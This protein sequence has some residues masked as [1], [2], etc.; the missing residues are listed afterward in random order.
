MYSRLFC[1]LGTS[2]VLATLKHPSSPGLPHPRRLVRVDLSLKVHFH[3]S[4]AGVV[5]PTRGTASRAC[6]DTLKIPVDNDSA[7]CGPGSR[8]RAGVVDTGR[9]STSCHALFHAAFAFVHCMST[10]AL[11]SEQVTGLRSACQQ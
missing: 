2:E 10:S 4:D 6:L 1:K 9:A 8:L 5:L 7:L 3:R 11:Q